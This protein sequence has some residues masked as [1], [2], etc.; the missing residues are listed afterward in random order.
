MQNEFVKGSKRPPDKKRA[1]PVVDITP[2]SQYDASGKQHRGFRKS[3]TARVVS[4]E[5]WPIDSD[6]LDTSDEEN[7]LVI[8]VLAPPG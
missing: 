8:R 3:R 2:T 7:A 4:P 1:L 5:T 6:F